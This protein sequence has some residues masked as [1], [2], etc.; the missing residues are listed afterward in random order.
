MI[1]E[2]TERIEALDTLIE[3]RAA[4]SPATH[5]VMQIVGVGAVT[6]T[7]LGITKSGDVYLRSLLVN[8]AHYI[9]SKKGPDTDLK[10]YG[11]RIAGKS[12]TAKKRAIVAVARK[13]AVLMHRLWLTGEEYEAIGYMQAQAAA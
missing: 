5:A 6:A 9:L 12:K 10:R 2:L 8:C 7:T 11:E 1:D 4:H 13:L 3:T